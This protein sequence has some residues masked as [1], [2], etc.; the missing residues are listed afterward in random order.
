[1]TEDG[2]EKGLAA[3][4]T[5]ADRVARFGFTATELDRFRLAYGRSFEQLA[6]SKDE[7]T[8]VSLA[9]EFVRNFIQ[10]EPIPG[11]AYENGLVKRFMPEITLGDQRPRARW[12]PDRN[13][14][15]VVSAEAGRPDDS[16][17]GEAGGRNQV[18]G[19]RYADGVRGLG[20]RQAAAR[21]VARARPRVERR[22][23]RRSASP[24]GR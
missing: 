4:F 5:E 7:H 15:V 17:R 23:R 2:I 8:S 22:R 1:M 6:S 3:L 21:S 16:D 19:R 24:N 13:R 10:Q 9:D 20:E 18:R 11:I 14:V 12:M